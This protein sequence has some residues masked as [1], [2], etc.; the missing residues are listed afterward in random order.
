M[1]YHRE[2]R[3][4]KGLVRFNIQHLA[5]PYTYGSPLYRTGIAVG[6]Y[7][8]DHHH[9]KNPL[10]PQHLEFYAVPSYSIPLGSLIPAQTKGLIV[11]EKGIS[12]SNVVNGTTRLQPVTILIGEAAGTLAALS[13]QQNRQP[14]NVP[15]RA[16]QSA[17]LYK[18]AF[19]MPYLD[20]PPTD[21]H[22]EMIQ[23]VGAT[24]I[25]KGKG[26]PYQ[27][28]NQT[29]FYPDS[30]ISASV[31]AQDFIDF[32]A[33]TAATADKLTIK[34]AL[35]AVGESCKKWPQ[36]PGAVQA[37]SDTSFVQWAMKE[38]ENWGLTDFQLYRPITRRELA[39]LLSYTL[40]PFNTLSVNHEG[41][42][43]R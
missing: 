36:S 29:W 42:F 38:W 25:L 34:A 20:V 12:V 2:G 11:A 39:V 6:D 9:K 19:L 13:V 8:I 33:F 5:T 1:P 28:A 3:R 16:V 24:G 43:I 31:F 32:H 30:V 35:D 17:L 22:F 18:K 7:P 40:D 15:V 21:P 26:I 4:V 10:A 37:I 23:K 41:Y 14:A 27:W